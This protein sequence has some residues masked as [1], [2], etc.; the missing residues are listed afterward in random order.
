MPA[1]DVPD[2]AKV[3][4]CAAASVSVLV[5]NVT[6]VPPVAVIT[7]EFPVRLA[8]KFGLALIALSTVL[9]VSPA[10][11]V[12]VNGVTPSVKASVPPVSAVPG[13]IPVPFC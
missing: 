6:G 8:V 10:A 3:S 7:R 5:V 4:A 9:S 12:K 13:K 1:V 2:V 11:A